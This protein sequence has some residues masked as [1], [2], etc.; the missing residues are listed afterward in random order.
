MAD[1]REQRV[2]ATDQIKVHPELPFVL[3]EFAKEVITKN[4]TNVI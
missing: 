4:P 3:K 1:V 2:F